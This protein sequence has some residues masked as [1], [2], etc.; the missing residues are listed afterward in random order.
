MCGCFT[1]CDEDRA[2]LPGTLGRALPD[3]LIGL[4]K[5]LRNDLPTFNDDS[6]WT[7]PI[8]AR[9]VI[10]QDRVIRYAKV[11]PDYTQRPEP[12]AMLTA[13]HG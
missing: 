6:S 5:N 1:G 8:P 13:I 4:Y 10:G 9:Y 7:L 3:D 11:N 12:Q 2:I